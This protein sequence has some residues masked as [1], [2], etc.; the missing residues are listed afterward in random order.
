MNVYPGEQFEGVMGFLYPSRFCF[1]LC[2][3]R[4]YA[5]TAGSGD[6]WVP[7]VLKDSSGMEAALLGGQ[8]SPFALD[9]TVHGCWKSHCFTGFGLL[10]CD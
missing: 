7:P 3:S 10:E 2:T 5:R 6:C 9:L 1:F 4:P 8:M